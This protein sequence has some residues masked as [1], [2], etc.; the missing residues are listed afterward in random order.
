MASQHGGTIGG[1]FDLGEPLAQILV[2]GGVQ[3]DFDLAVDDGQQIIEIVR[4]SSGELSYGLHFLRL[5]ELVFE[6]LFDR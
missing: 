5:D 2:A 3:N 1:L 4:H 6:V